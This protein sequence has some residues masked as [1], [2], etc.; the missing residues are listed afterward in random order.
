MI[1]FATESYA[2]QD[3]ILSDPRYIR[4]YAEVM[5]FDAEKQ[6]FEAVNYLLHQCTSDEF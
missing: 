1:A 3:K 5:N 4:Y 6:I 2:Y